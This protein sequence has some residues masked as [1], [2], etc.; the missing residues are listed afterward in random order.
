V[1]HDRRHASGAHDGVEY[2]L[3]R[4]ELG[5]R[6]VHARA[7]PIAKP[8]GG[9]PLVVEILEDVTQRREAER[10]LMHLAR[11]DALTDLPNRTV[12]YEALHDALAHAG[13]HGH[14]VSVLLIDA[15]DFKSVNDTFGHV[16]GDLVL[17]EFAGRLASCVR[18]GDTVG[19]LG[20]D[21]FAVVVP[22]PARS[23]GGIE[24]ADRIR[25]ALKVPFQLEGRALAMSASIGIAS[26]PHDAA[27]LQGLIR[28]ADMAMYEAKAAGRDTFRCYRA[29][30]R[31]RPSQ[32]GNGAAPALAIV[33][34]WSAANA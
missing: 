6:W 18:P 4:P 25:E 24:I 29:L 23:H 3:V 9:E 8:A 31:G 20:G 26:Y 12:L 1:V 22:T 19:R 5:V 33:P 28:H 16:A 10:R 13:R 2:R 7:F 15:D 21:E 30:H 17:R 34:S 14:G 32:K 27:D 11:H